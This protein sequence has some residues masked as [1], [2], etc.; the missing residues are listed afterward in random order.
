[1]F[2]TKKMFAE[3]KYIPLCAVDWLSVKCNNICVLCSISQFSISTA[4][5]I[6]LFVDLIASH[7]PRALTALLRFKSAP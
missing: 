1:M 4:M 2:A 3:N 6:L 5:A 7:K